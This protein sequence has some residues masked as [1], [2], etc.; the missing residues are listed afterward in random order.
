MEDMLATGICVLETPVHGKL[1]DWKA[2][3]YPSPR[4]TLDPEHPG[5][6]RCTLDSFRPPA[7]DLTLQPDQGLVRLSVCLFACFVVGLFVCLFVCLFDCL[8]VCLFACLL[9]C[10]LISSSRSYSSQL[11]DL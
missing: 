5:L 9:V 11:H 2:P 10:F 1:V 4:W 8:L 3:V 7:L 6:G